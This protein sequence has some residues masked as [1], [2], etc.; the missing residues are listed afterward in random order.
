AC[1]FLEHPDAHRNPVTAKTVVFSSAAT[2]SAW[3][4]VVVT[5][6]AATAPAVKAA[7]AAIIVIV[8]FMFSL[9]ARML[10]YPS[11]ARTKTHLSGVPSI[12]LPIRNNAFV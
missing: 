12:F 5:T 6:G 8:V 1:T 11:T 10:D 4:V 3:V 7:K 9:V 2:T